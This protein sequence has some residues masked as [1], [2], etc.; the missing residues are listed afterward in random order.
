[1]RGWYVVHS[2]P[3]KEQWLCNQFNALQIEAYYPCLYA[4]DGKSHVHKPKP[5][6]PGYLFVN[7]DLELTGISMLQWVPGSLGLV[8]FGGEPACVPDGLVQTIRHRVDEM[9][10]SKGNML[11]SLRSGDEVVIRSGPFTGY[12]AIFHSRLHDSERVQVL[13]RILQKQTIRVNLRVDQLG[14]K[15]QNRN[16]LQDR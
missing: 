12:D 2:K 15:K 6:F 13:L 11:E 8:S 14:F 10:N 4:S 5:Y 3:Q 16:L 7:V 1:M 9:T